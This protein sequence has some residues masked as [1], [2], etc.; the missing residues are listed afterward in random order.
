MT[1]GGR[2]R[3]D[4]SGLLFSAALA[5]FEASL[6]SSS[7]ASFQVVMA[8]SAGA[9]TLIVF[10]SRET[11]G[12]E[13][14]AQDQPRRYG[15]AVTLQEALELEWPTDAHAATYAPDHATPRERRKG[16]PRMR[17]SVLAS[18]RAKKRDLVADLML[19][20]L[21]NP[22]HAVHNDESFARGIERIDDLPEHLRPMAW[23]STRAG[24]RYCYT[25]N[26][27]LPVDEFE[28]AHRGWKEVL[29][30]AGLP[31]DLE[32]ASDWTHLYRM[33]RVLRDGE[34][35]S[36]S[37]YF[38]CSE[39]EDRRLDIAKI[40][41]RGRLSKVPSPA[42]A[43]GWPENRPQGDDLA[44][45]LN[46][47]SDFIKSARRVLRSRGTYAIVFEGS[48]L[49]AKGDRDVTMFGAVRQI[50]EALQ[51][52]AKD[53]ADP[54]HV[55]ALLY[56][57]VSELEPDEGKDWLVV[58]WE[59]AVREWQHQQGKLTTQV[60][61]NDSEGDHQRDLRCF[62]TMRTIYNGEM[63][64]DEREAINWISQ[65][66]LLVHKTEVYLLN[67]HTGYYHD[68]P[69][70]RDDYVGM[71]RSLKA[72]SFL[73]WAN[74][75]KEDVVTARRFVDVV[76]DAGLPISN[77]IYRPT[78][79]P[80]P[81]GWLE[82]RDL[83]FPAYHLRE[84]LEPRRSEQVDEWYSALFGVQKELAEA[85]IV[86]ALD[87]CAG[88]IPALCAYG[89]PGCGKTLFVRGMAECYSNEVAASGHTELATSYQTRDLLKTPFVWFDEGF[90]ITKQ[91]FSLIF[92][93]WVGGTS[94]VINE[95]FRAAQ[96][97][98]TAPRVISTGNHPDM[99][100]AFSGDKRILSQ[101]D[102][103]ALAQRILVL[104]MRGNASKLLEERGGFQYTR[105]WI[106]E[107]NRHECPYTVARH[108]LWLYNHL[109]RKPLG[110]RFL[111]IGNA[112]DHISRELRTRSGAAPEVLRALIQLLTQISK[113]R[114]LCA[115][116]IAIENGYIYVTLNGVV[117]HISRHQAEFSYRH[118]TEKIVASVL[119]A[120]GSTPPDSSDVKIASNKRRR[121]A[122]WWL[123]DA[124]N[125]MEYAQEIGLDSTPIGELVD[126]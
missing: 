62:A 54:P 113:R 19:F 103:E 82:G 45:Y 81:G 32:C 56:R 100:A 117:Q 66:R 51:Q 49:G 27:P 30:A 60:K 97:I 22:G 15:R 95:K 89:P 122:R 99:L 44:V 87:V 48:P 9:A 116:A 41:R 76:V 107:G 63:P 67:P 39:I 93:Q 20:D 121:R 25:L 110:G 70:G 106:R 47:G 79:F 112:F 102:T 17:K 86:R 75:T 59:K 35:T 24:W 78:R 69:C 40:P 53:Y 38:Y 21:D 72:T 73:P 7:L 77:V 3:F 5:T 58:L 29:Q 124:W 43:E 34:R 88:P 85:Y 68:F 125:L 92:R 123:V 18:V 12:L 109:D 2:A 6:S 90:P 11:K 31:V 108:N 98:Q 37:R 118:L 115:D 4:V 52:G 74:V 42:S 65:R 119:S 84:D 13:S 96:Q 26:E 55:Y 83:C 36:A 46:D 8:E 80:V 57:A 16:W 104:T 28:T 71:L 50:F 105:G 101:D 14:L 23:Y 114:S 91:D 64:Q 94:I 1:W 126:A 120:N 33:P 111:M 61:G 10:P